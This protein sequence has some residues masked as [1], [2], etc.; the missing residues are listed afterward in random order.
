MARPPR[1]TP[2]PWHEPHFCDDTTTCNCAFILSECYMGSVAT[3]ACIDVDNRMPISE[4]G[5]DAPPLAEAQA[6]ARLIT[7]APELRALL[8]RMLDGDARDYALHMT[9]ASLLIEEIDG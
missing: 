4:G 8:V 9:E 5:N 3:I 2:A 1:H 6:N 7:R